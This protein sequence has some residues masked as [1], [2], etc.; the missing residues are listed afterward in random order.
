MQSEPQA[1]TSYDAQMKVM[2]LLTVPPSNKDVASN[3]AHIM[4]FKTGSIP[5]IYILFGKGTK[6][7]QEATLS[8]LR[9]I[10][11]DPNVTFTVKSKRSTPLLI[12]VSWRSPTTG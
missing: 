10:F 8:K 2:P 9:G 11:P 3:A 12:C 6:L 4:S 1:D 5:R 7:S